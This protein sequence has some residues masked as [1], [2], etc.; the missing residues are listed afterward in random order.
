[1]LVHKLKSRKIQGSIF[2]DQVDKVVAAIQRCPGKFD[3]LI[4]WKFNKKINLIPDMA[5]VKGSHF[6]FAKPLLYR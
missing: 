4:Q 1:M 6:V 5:I 2:L 3:Y